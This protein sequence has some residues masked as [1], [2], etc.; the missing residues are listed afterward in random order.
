MQ[1]GATGAGGGGGAD[2]VVTTVVVV[3]WLAAGLFASCWLGAAPHA[4]RM[5]ATRAVEPPRR[6]R[7][8]VTPRLPFIIEP[9]AMKAYIDA[10]V[11]KYLRLAKEAGIQPE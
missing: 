6:K 1:G 3:G 7:R 5:V 8:R 2:A 9:D 10:E 11:T 4:A